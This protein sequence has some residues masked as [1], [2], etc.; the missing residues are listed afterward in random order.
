MAEVIS[1]KA[2]EVAKL[3]FVLST[4]SQEQISE[5]VVAVI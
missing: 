2:V 4:L 1:S 3:Q 5:R